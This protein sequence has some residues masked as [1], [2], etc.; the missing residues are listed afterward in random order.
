MVI[1]DYQL[2]DKSCDHPGEELALATTVEY[3]HN[4][5]CAGREAENNEQLWFQSE[6]EVP[7][8]TK[9]QYHKGHIENN[10]YNPDIGIESDAIDTSIIHEIPD[11][12]Y[13]ALEYETKDG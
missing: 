10:I 4:L 1:N 3:E 5:Q 9:G 13:P 2:S 6:L 8:Y 7:C 11:P 12:R